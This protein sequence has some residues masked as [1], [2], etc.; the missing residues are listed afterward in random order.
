MDAAGVPKKRSLGH[1]AI[2]R[3]TIAKPNHNI[4]CQ[5]RN[6]DRQ[7]LEGVLPSAGDSAFGL[8]NLAVDLG[9]KHRKTGIG[10]TLGLTSRHI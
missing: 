3:S 5:L 10:D 7:L 1:A 2:D 6:Q 8:A 4:L 9:I